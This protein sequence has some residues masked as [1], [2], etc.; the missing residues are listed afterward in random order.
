MRSLFRMRPASIR[1]TWW[2]FS[3]GIFGCMYSFVFSFEIKID[4]GNRNLG[5]SPEES[6]ISLIQTVYGQ[7]SIP[8]FELLQALVNLI[9]VVH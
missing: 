9:H 7:G 5:R 1:I 2:A 3:S 8:E 6:D 4:E